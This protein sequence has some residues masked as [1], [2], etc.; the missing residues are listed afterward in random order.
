MAGA[1]RTARATGKILILRR[2]QMKE[3][4]AILER[5]RDISMRL[6]D[7]LEALLEALRTD[8]SGSRVSR[9]VQDIEPLLSELPKLLGDQE[10]FLA[11]CGQPD[12]DSFV[13]A[14]PVSS[15]RDA[16]LR[17][18][19]EI[20]QESDM[21]RY[22][23]DMSELLL[24]RNKEFID[25]HINVLSATSAGSTYGSSGLGASGGRGSG[26]FDKNV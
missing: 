5:Q 12:M 14:Q 20:G 25:Y 13:Q 15:E 4:I 23:L 18:L 24:Q 19:D 7:L 2:E 9:A 22:Q 17:L 3:A 11:A 8:T 6:E 26:M 1:A 10:R 21:L 16:A